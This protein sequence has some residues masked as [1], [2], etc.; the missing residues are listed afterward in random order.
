MAGVLQ[1]QLITDAQAL[2]KLV[3]A[4][5]QESLVACDLEADSLHH[6]QEQVCLLQF[7]TA[8]ANYLVDPLAIRDLSPLVPFF[9]NPDIC[10]IFHGADYDVRSLF[11]DFGIEIVNLF[12]TMIAC[13]F[14][15]EKE[16]GLAGALKKRFNVMLD[17]QF[18]T[19]DWSQ[20]PLPGVC[21]TGYGPSDF[22][23][24]AGDGRI[25][26]EKSSV[27]G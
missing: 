15:G 24:L 14:L 11:R 27:L 10:K 20:R 3:A 2:Q 26:R 7:S 23:L 8:T 21:G 1:F 9:A 19:A 5:S 13:Q 17:K 22:I 12:D 16:W 18:Q 6:Y 4:L 25:G